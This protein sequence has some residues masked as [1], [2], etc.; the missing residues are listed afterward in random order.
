MSSNLLQEIRNERGDVE[1]PVP[2]TNLSAKDI[3]RAARLSQ[4]S[5]VAPRK[6]DAGPAVIAKGLADL[7][8]YAFRPYGASQSTEW[9]YMSK[10]DFEAIHTPYQLVNID[11]LTEAL[12]GRDQ[13]IQTLQSRIKRMAEEVPAKRLKKLM[14]KETEAMTSDET[15]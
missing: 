8:G 5:F 14:R 15:V 11:A 4:M 3:A 6:D 13:T 10:D 7:G 2:T 1:S 9:E 12:T